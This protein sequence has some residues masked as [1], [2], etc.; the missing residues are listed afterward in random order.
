MNFQ[1]AIAV[2]RLP[3]W[4]E[5]R[6]PSLFRVLCEKGWGTNYGPPIDGPGYCRSLTG[7]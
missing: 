3:E 1:V 4:S 5:A 7:R 2:G 6:C